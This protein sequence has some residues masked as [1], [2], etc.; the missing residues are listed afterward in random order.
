MYTNTRALI[1]LSP[2][3]V[4]LRQD[5]VHLGLYNRP[6]GNWSVETNPCSI[7][8]RLGPN[9]LRKIILEKV[10]EEKFLDGF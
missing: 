8:L 10:S 1:R 2:S 9:I 4:T 5:W 6:H 7:H 3:D